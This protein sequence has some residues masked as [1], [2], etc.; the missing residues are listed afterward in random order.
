MK[1]KYHKYNI[2][3]VGSFFSPCE[4]EILSVLREEGPMKTRWVVQKCSFEY[5]TVLNCL[6]LLRK[7]GF[8]EK[9]NVSGYVGIWKVSS[10]ERL[11]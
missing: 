10:D 11:Y 6:R 3:A 2:R 8:I 7:A 1:H 9:S 5:Q 4:L